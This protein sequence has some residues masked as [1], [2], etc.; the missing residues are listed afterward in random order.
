[1]FLQN[2]LEFLAAASFWV[3]WSRVYNIARTRC[4]SSGE[5]V[6]LFSERSFSPEAILWDAS[7]SSEIKGGLQRKRPEVTWCTGDNSRCRGEQLEGRE[8][9]RAKETV[10]RASCDC[11]LFDFILLKQY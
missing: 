8:V 9:V 10:L 5:N 7:Q 3:A 4:R 11:L 1:M 6:H 2:H